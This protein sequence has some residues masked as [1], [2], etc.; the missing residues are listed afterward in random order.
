MSDKFKQVTALLKE[1]LS[2]NKAEIA[3]TA[4]NAEEVTGRKSKRKKIRQELVQALSVR[5]T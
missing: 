1:L 4:P 3:S 2:L 5:D